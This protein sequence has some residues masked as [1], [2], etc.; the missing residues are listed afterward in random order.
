MENLYVYDVHVYIAYTNLSA[1]TCT[2]C[3]YHT[4]KL[5]TRTCTVHLMPLLQMCIVLQM[6]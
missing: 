4:K 3:Y 2:V 5:H 1:A 6:T